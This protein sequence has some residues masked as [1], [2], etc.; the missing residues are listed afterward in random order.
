MYECKICQVE[1]EKYGSFSVHC[2]RKHKISYIDLKNEYF[3]KEEKEFKCNRCDDSFDV[4]EGLRKHSSRLHKIKSEYFYVEF[5]LNGIN[6][7]CKCGCGE[8]VKFTGHGFKEYK[9]GHISRINNNYT[10]NNQKSIDK[11]ANT[12]RLQYKNGERK[13]WNDGLTKE[14]SDIVR[15]IGEASTKENNPERAKKISNSLTGIPKSEEHNRKNTE[16]W[17]EYWS[18]KENRDAQ[19]IRHVKYMKQYL[20]RNETKLEK[21]FKTILDNLNIKYEFQP[22]VGG[23]NYDFLINTNLIVE[24]DGDFWHCNPIKWKEPIYESQK[25]TVE[26]DA[27][28]NQWAKNNGYKLLRF[29]E[30]D[31]NENPAKVIKTLLNEMKL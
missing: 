22:S 12:R 8:K 24:V 5:Y 28:K 3:P 20:I 13:V 29:W 1:F 2:N 16:H 9:V 6:P 7:I 10:Y 17:R 21:L 4:Y 31:I 11:S 25:H 30:T 27:V 23:F 19:R 18:K 14:T 15:Q 26:H